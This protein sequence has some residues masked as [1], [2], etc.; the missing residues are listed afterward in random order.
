MKKS[1]KK[2]EKT[3]RDA[4]TTVC[5]TALETTSGFVWLTHIVNFNAFPSSLKVICV[6]ETDDDLSTANHNKQTDHL[7]RLIVD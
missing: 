5:E 7:N 6:F 4:L 3:L 2:I 1:D